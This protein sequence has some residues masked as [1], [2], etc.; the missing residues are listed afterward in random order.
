MINIWIIIGIL[1]GLVIILVVALNYYS[2]KIHNETLKNINKIF[3]GIKSFFLITIGERIT[4]ALE[5]TDDPDNEEKE[6][7]NN[8]SHNH[9]GTF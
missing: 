7:D 9:D 5:Q 4:G 3:D 6:E 1:I 2:N 8:D